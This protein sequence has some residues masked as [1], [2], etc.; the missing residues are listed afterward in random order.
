[1]SIK[2]RIE[3]DSLG[4]KNIPENAYYGIQSERAREN[5]DVSGLALGNYTEFI[6]AIAAIKKAAAIANAKSLDLSQ[7][8]ADAIVTATDE[9]LAGKFNDQFLM[10]IFQG[11]GGTSANMNVNEVVAN[12][13]NEI[14][15]GSKG[16]ETVHPNTHVN[17]GQSTNDVIPSAMKIASYKY[18]GNLIISIKY[19]EDALKIKKDEFKNIVKIGRTCLQDALPITLGQEFGGYLSYIKRRKQDIINIQHKCLEIPLGATAIGTKVSIRD[20]YI[21]NVYIELSK[22]VKMDLKIDEDL[23]DALQNADIYLDISAGMKTLSTGLSKIATDLRILSSGPNAGF[24]EITLPAV[25]PGSSIMP[26]KVNPVMPEL[27]NQICYQVCGNDTAISMA[28]EGGEL[29]LN[30]WEPVIIKCI[31]ESATLL[32]NGVKLFVDKCINGITANKEICREYSEKSIALSTVIAMI[33]DYPT[34]SKIAKEAV[35]SGLSIKEVAIKNNILSEADANI[36]L[37]PFLLTDGELLAKKVDE[38][39]KENKIC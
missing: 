1:M 5:F 2:F 17:M 7:K 22:I 4:T 29:D 14:L 39:K 13:A 32:T 3:E 19:I 35:K 10:D 16:Y 37:D 30:V 25:Q 15:T 28:C 6:Y 23:F 33:F 12:R 18:L 31:A 20:N 38:Y 9:L 36:L 8:I 24:M 21:E 27:I 26:G 11:G 34:G